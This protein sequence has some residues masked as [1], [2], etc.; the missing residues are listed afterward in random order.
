[1]QLVSEK[2]QQI[3]PIGFIVLAITI[4]VGAIVFGA[5]DAASATIGLNTAATQAVQ[6]VTA[7]TYSGF[8]IISIGPIVAAAVVILAIIGLLGAR[9]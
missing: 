4:I 9:R 6:N 5:F 7:N 3:G 8:N 2:A 1:M